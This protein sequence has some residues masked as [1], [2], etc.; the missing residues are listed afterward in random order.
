[1]I[2][3]E[4]LTHVDNLLEARDRVRRV[5]AIDSVADDDDWN[6]TE[7]GLGADN[8]KPSQAVCAG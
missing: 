1:M 6:I 3:A 8:G 2:L 4:L 5:D 7:L